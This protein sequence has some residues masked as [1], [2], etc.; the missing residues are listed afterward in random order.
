MSEKNTKQ[1]FVS[2]LSGRY[3]GPG[4][5]S[6]QKTWSGAGKNIW[7][8]FFLV[9]AVLI[10]GVFVVVGSGCIATEKPVIYLYPETEMEVLVKL[11]YEG[12][13]TCTYPL[14]QD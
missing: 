14:Y 8:I 2:P 3:G 11:D 13:L 10:V 6:P 5:P 1:E 9:C 12:E 4:M 7:R